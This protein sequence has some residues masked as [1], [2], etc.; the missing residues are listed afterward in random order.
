MT[1]TKKKF[2]LL[3]FSLRS[4]FRNCNSHAH[5]SLVT[6]E[7]VIALEESIVHKLKRDY[8]ELADW[9]RW[10]DWKLM[11]KDE[12]RLELRLV[13][14]QVLH[15][16]TSFK[17]FWVLEKDSRRGK[18]MK[19]SYGRAWLFFRCVSTSILSKFTH[20]PT[21]SLTHWQC[22]HFG[23]LGRFGQFEHLDTLETLNT[24]N[25]LDTLGTVD[26]LD[27]LDTL[28]MFDIW[29][30]FNTLDTLDALDT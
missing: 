6:N 24:L 13:R 18:T 3:G 29:D 1:V 28:D 9:R 11:W 2:E 16:N 30:I 10:R 27:I 15:I 12:L 14:L 17:S 20:K 22:R 5:I 25:T 23:H 4:E 7:E 26:T 8:Q 21:D 19:Y